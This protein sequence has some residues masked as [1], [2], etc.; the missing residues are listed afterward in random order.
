MSGGVASL[1]IRSRASYQKSTQDSR[2]H[3]ILLQKDVGDQLEKDEDGNAGDRGILPVFGTL[4]FSPTSLN[5]A[6]QRRSKPLPVSYLLF[7]SLGNGTTYHLGE[8][9]RWTL[10]PL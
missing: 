8:N 4:I 1:S 6:V 7:I 2:H 10:Q 3:D 9:F 5:S